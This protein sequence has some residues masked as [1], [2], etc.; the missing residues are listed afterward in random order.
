[1]ILV[2]LSHGIQMNYMLAAKLVNK[3]P[4]CQGISY[5]PGEFHGVF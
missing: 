3:L 5:H 4:K 2:T 1:M